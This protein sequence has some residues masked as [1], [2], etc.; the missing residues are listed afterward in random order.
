MTF[1]ETLIYLR[2]RTKKGAKGVNKLGQEVELSDF[3]RG[4]A[5]GKYELLC[6]QAKVYNQNKNNILQIEVNGNKYPVDYVIKQIQSGK[7]IVTYPGRKTNVKTNP[8]VEKLS[9]N[10]NER[11]EKL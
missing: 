7:L 11:F 9:N 4:R 6:E 1:K 5:M 2:S 3:E 10:I 8:W